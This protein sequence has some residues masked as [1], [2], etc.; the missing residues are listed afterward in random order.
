M[1]VHFEKALARL[2]RLLDEHAARAQEAVASAVEAVEA[3]NAQLAACVV[4]GDRAI[5]LAE[6]RIEEACLE[7]LAL[8]QPVAGDLRR[9]MTIFKVNGEIERAGDLAVAVARQAEALAARTGRP[10][11]WSFAAIGARAREQLSAALR[12]LREHDAAAAHAVI[13]ADDAVDA[14]YRAGAQRAAA[15]VR[16]DPEGADE[17]LAALSAFRSLE[18]VG[19]VA[20]NIAEDVIYL[21]TAELVRHGAG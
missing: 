9:V 5:D 19:D 2:E 7:I 12:A 13:R 10:R 21:E 3:A 18:R 11:P 4:E 16:K 14:L 15:A 1:K 20:T 8:Y 17:A 6:N